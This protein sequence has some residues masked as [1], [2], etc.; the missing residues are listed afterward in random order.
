MVRG[1]ENHPAPRSWLRCTTLSGSG[2]VRFSA[3]S[4]GNSQ[5][6]LIGLGPAPLGFIPL[7]AASQPGGAAA[8]AGAGAGLLAAT[9]WAEGAVSA[10]GRT[11]ARERLPPP[12]GGGTALR[13][14]SRCPTH[15]RG[16]AG[17]QPLAGAAGLAAGGD[18]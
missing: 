17:F 15:L 13:V 4:T 16:D 1:S 12:A 6:P 8:A 2:G 3:G 11:G 5:Q 14:L 10:A 18:Q 7:A 9:G